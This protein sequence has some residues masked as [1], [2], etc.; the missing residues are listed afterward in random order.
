VQLG[1]AGNQPAKAKEALERLRLPV[2]WI[3]NSAELGA[4]KPSPEFFARVAGKAGLPPN[5]I[6]Y[7]GDRLDNDVVPAQ[8]AGMRSV[9][10]VRGP[11]GEAHAIWPEARQALVTISTLHGIGEQL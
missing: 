1:L 2:D 5:Q 7:V 11:W 6:A 4:E 10:L 3:A 9:F 8:A